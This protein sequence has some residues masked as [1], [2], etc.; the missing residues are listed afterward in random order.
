M[1]EFDT[2]WKAQG[3]IEPRDPTVKEQMRIAFRAGARAA[4]LG[5]RMESRKEAIRVR[6]EL[7]AAIENRTHHAEWFK[8]TGWGGN[9]RAVDE[10]YILAAEIREDLDRICP[11]EED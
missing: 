4:A 2:Y 8:E 10:P 5:A 11:E 1:H 7:L 6:Q 3:R 9:G